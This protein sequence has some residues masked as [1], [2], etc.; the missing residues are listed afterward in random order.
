MRVPTVFLRKES[1]FNYRHVV[2][3][4]YKLCVSNSLNSAVIFVDTQSYKNTSF[5]ATFGNF[6]EFTNT[7]ELEFIGGLCKLFVKVSS[8]VE[9]VINL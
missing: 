2:I 9:D 8:Y 3:E 5:C 6:G 1:F 4:A 7:G